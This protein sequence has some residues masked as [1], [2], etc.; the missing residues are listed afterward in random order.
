MSFF[1]NRILRRIFG[2]NRDQMTTALRNT[3]PEE[4]HN[5]YSSPHIIVVARSKRMRWAE[6][7]VRMEDKKFIQNFGS[8]A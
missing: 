3:N 7:I 1:Q 6:R 8:E 2:P 4:L 5:L